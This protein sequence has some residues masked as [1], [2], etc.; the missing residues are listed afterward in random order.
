MVTYI[1]PHVNEKN[2]A[3]KGKIMHVSKL[4]YINR[5]TMYTYYIIH[6][7]TPKQ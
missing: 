4:S 2:V 6:Y 7:N 3:Q 5:P 1:V